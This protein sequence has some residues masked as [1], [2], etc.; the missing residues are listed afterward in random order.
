MYY[1]IT[2]RLIK[3]EKFQRIY[4]ETLTDG[5]VREVFCQIGGTTGDCYATEYKINQAKD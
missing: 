5:T 1:T 3:H 4:T 2:Y